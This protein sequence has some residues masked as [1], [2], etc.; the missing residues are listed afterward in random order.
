MAQ[1]DVFV[2]P[3]QG[4]PTDEPVSVKGVFNGEPITIDVEMKVP[5]EPQNPEN[6]DKGT[7]LTLDNNMLIVAGVALALIVLL[8]VLF[9]VLIKRRGNTKV[10]KGPEVISIINDESIVYA[11]Q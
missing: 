9:V 4:L 6:N 2:I 10:Q 8:V 3:L 5:V 7:S 11:E 1:E